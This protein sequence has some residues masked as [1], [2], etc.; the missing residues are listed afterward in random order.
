MSF[1]R[2]HEHARLEPVGVFQPIPQVLR[3]VDQG[4]RPQHPPAAHVGQVRTGPGNRLRIPDG[5][6]SGAAVTHEHLVA[7]LENLRVGVGTRLLLLRHP[8][9]KFLRRL[10]NDMERHPRVLHAAEFGTLAPVNPLAVRLEPEVGRQVRKHVHLAVQLR[11]PEAVNHV[12]R[13]QLEPHR[14][15]HRNVNLVGVHNAVLGVLHLPPK[16]MPYN[17]D[18][19]PRLRRPQAGGRLDRIKQ[20]AEQD[21]EGQDHAA[22]QDEQIAVVRR[23]VLLLGPKDG[24]EEQGKRTRRVDPANRQQDPPQCGDR[25]R[26]RTGRMQRRLDPL[27]LTTG[28]QQRQ[29][30]PEPDAPRDPAGVHPIPPPGS[31]SHPPC[32]SRVRHR[33]H[34]HAVGPLSLWCSGLPHVA[35]VRDG[36]Y[37]CL[38]IC[39]CITKSMMRFNSSSVSR[40]S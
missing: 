30:H 12:P 35:V 4:R 8:S 19:Q 33:S 32:I 40:P 38:V 10:G 34:P 1:R 31:G 13:R 14:L 37:R 26:C 20:Q 25:L 17:A 16:T 28:N 15:A 9:G 23:R 29:H 5:V 36:V 39:T 7:P 22:H 3:R 24:V 6:A 11:D 2:R 27:A 18:R 21:E